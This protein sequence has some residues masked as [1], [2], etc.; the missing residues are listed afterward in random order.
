MSVTSKD[1]SFHPAST[2]LS[3]DLSADTEANLAALYADDAPPADPHYQPPFNIMDFE[4][5]LSQDAFLHYQQLNK[6][7]RS[8]HP[9]RLGAFLPLLSQ[10]VTTNEDPAVLASVVNS[11]SQHQP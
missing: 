7:V 6:T 4:I 3:D 11:W 1:S 9:N 10:A 5:N 8:T 2:I